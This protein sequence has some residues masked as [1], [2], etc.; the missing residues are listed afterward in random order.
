MTDNNNNNNRSSAFFM[1]GGAGRMLSSI[2]A[3][4]LF[5]EEN[6]NDDFIIVCEGGSELYKGH[7]LLHERAYDHYHKDLF[8]DKLKNRNC[9]SPEPYR[10]WEYYNQKCNL[11]QAFDI[12]INNKG[13]RK[14]KN[15]SIYLSQ[16]E[17]LGGIHTV[18]EVKEKTKKSK[19]IVFQPFGRTSH[20]HNDVRHDSTGRSL[21]LADTVEIIKALQKDYAVLLM[22]EQQLDTDKLGIKEPLAVP[23]NITLRQ[24]S[25]IIA[26]ADYFLGIDSVGQ[27][28]A[29]SFGKKATVIIGPTYPENI[30]YPDSN[31]FDVLDFGGDKRKYDPIRLSQDEVSARNNESLLQ[32][33]KIAIE[34]IIKSVKNNIEGKSVKNGK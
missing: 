14:L 21:T 11:A 6:P 4:E 3:L 18:K 10:V 32:L 28:I 2:P 12:A 9:F 7:P 16:E 34:H 25:G 23:Q 13:I 8:K 20:V 5:A 30:S 31:N 15:S 29:N 26:E 1:N 22:A 27:H 24:W 19:V 17:F 33:N